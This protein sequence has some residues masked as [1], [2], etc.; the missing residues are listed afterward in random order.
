MGPWRVS[1][2]Q[3]PSKILLRQKCSK[4]SKFKLKSLSCMSLYWILVQP[5]STKWVISWLARLCRLRFSENWI[6]IVPK[7]RDKFGILLPSVNSLRSQPRRLS[8]SRENRPLE[9][10]FWYKVVLLESSIIYIFTLKL[11]SSLKG[12]PFWVRLGF[13]WTVQ[14]QQHSSAIPMQVYFSSI[15]NTSTTLN[16]AATT[17]TNLFEATSVNTVTKWRWNVGECWENRSTIYKGV[18]TN[19]WTKL[20]SKCKR[21]TSRKALSSFSSS[22]KPN[23]P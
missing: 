17:S 20:L 9:C 10:L 23:T 21:L 11:T 2:F 22:V 3:C 12:A 8:L 19:F 1:M 15:G 4:T 5:S 13:S 7:F 18:Q 16:S 14:G 6:W